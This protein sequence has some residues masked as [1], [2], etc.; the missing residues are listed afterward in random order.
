MTNDKDREEAREI[1]DDTCI[2]DVCNHKVERIAAAINRIR[3][4]AV[5]AERERCKDRILALGPKTVV[6]S[7]GLITIESAI[8]AILSDDQEAHDAPHS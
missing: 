2:C 7:R 1:F 5:K 3:A 4:D 8:D 6:G